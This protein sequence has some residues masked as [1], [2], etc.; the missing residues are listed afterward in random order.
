[1]RQKMKDRNEERERQ[2]EEY[3]KRWTN[4]AKDE[5]GSTANP[6]PPVAIQ[7]MMNEDKKSTSDKN[8][9]PNARSQVQI[10]FN[11]AKSAD[12]EQNPDAPRRSAPVPVIGKMP[13]R[14]AKSKSKT[15]ERSSDRFGAPPAMNMPP[16]GVYGGLTTSMYMQAITATMPTE[17][18]P[19]EQP[20]NPLKPPPPTAER[21]P[22]PQQTDI[23]AILAAA[24]AHISKKKAEFAANPYQA[25]IEAA[26]Q[27]EIPLPPLPAAMD[28]DPEALTDTRPVKLP[29]P[30]P[31][32][33]KTELD[34]MLE[35]HGHNNGQRL[36]DEA[37]QP[38]EPD[39]D[40]SD[41]AMLGIDPDDLAGFGS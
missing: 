38:A 24:Q 12:K 6:P 40:E 15:P 20:A 3:R 10:N 16:P 23:G 25:S 4:N 8:Q 34:L 32:K 5:S 36:N 1:M 35:K 30:P 2:K 18:P 13:G 37:Q 33:E 41:L 21:H 14:T 17:P 39:D 26:K 11:R 19:P 9:L 31:P 22:T 27:D 7:S 29:T 28:K